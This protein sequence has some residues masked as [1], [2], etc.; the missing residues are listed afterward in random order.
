M[1]LHG[2]LLVQLIACPIGRLLLALCLFLAAAHVPEGEEAAPRCLGGSGC[3]HLECPGVPS[4]MLQRRT[5]GSVAQGPE[6]D[7]IRNIAATLTGA[8]EQDVQSGAT[9]K[10]RRTQSALGSLLSALSFDGLVIGA[11]V[12]M[13]CLARR[14]CPNVYAYNVVAGKAPSVKDTSELHGFRWVALAWNVASSDAAVDY[15]GLDGAMYLEFINMSINICAAIGLPLAVLVAP[16]NIYYGGG[17]EHDILSKAAELNVKAGSKLY[18]RDALIVWYVVFVVHFFAQRSHE[19]FRRLRSYWLSEMQPPQS[20]TIIVQDLAEELCS[21]EALRKFMTKLFAA[22]AVESAFVVRAEDRPDAPF[23][24]NGFVT[25]ARRTDLEI[26]LNLKLDAQET[27]DMNVITAAP[28][29]EDIQYEVLQQEDANPTRKAMTGR[30]LMIVLFLVYLPFVFLVSVVTSIEV[31]KT[32]FPPFASVCRSYPNFENIWEGIVGPASL[33]ILPGF[34][35]TFLNMIIQGYYA[36]PSTSWC[37]STLERWYFYFQVTFTLVIFSLS[38][39]L[40]DLYTMLLTRPQDLLT[41]FFPAIQRVAVF[42]I[43]YIPVS[44]VAHSSQLLRLVNLLKFLWYRR[45]ND[46]EEA[47]KLSEPEDQDY[48]GIGSRSARLS[49]ILVIALVYCTIEPCI[50][51]VAWLDFLVCRVVYGYLMVFAEGRKPDSGGMIWI[52]QLKQVQLGLF[53]YVSLQTSIIFNSTHSLYRGAPGYIAALAY[54]QIFRFY[55]EHLEL[56]RLPFEQVMALD[57]VGKQKDF[58]NGYAQPLG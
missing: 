35:P 53:L 2:S 18:W 49:L 28:A 24:K 9:R 47:H 31:L 50:S 27:D 19:K 12:V 32:W 5:A 39:S 55:S 3:E 46:E 26:A 15:V 11:Y 36:L 34:V 21:D 54:L 29:P 43:F 23:G 57:A 37:Q 52:S 51:F 22:D 41:E 7:A 42:Y 48:Y 13:F 30:A 56:A 20:H 58:A 25:F 33:T 10:R 8:L 38:S 45:S 1:A 17:H 14:Y 44:T 4:A 40:L 6:E 16:S